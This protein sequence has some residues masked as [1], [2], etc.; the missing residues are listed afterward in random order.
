MGPVPG[1]RKGRD[2]V[3][4]LD[5]LTT[6]GQAAPRAGETHSAEASSITRERKFVSIL[7]AD[8]RESTSLVERMDPEDAD[9]ALSPVIDLM[10]K[11]AERFGGTLSRVQGDGIVA[12]FGAPRAME[13]HAIAA[14]HA[15]LDIQE[16]I[17][18]NR[19]RDIAVRIGIHSAEVLVEYSTDQR[20]PHCEA[21]GPAMHLAARIE[22]AAGPGEICI[23]SDSF[24][25]SRGY[26]ETTGPI[27]ITPKGFTDPVEVYKVQRRNLVRSR[28]HARIEQ[29]LSSF[30]SRAGEVARIDQAIRAAAAGAG[31]AVV[32]EGPAGIGK[33]RL[34][35]EA[36]NRSADLDP[37]LLTVAGAP[38]AANISYLPIT[39]ALRE[40]MRVPE[41]DDPTLQAERLDAWLAQFGDDIKAHRPAFMDLL[42]IPVDHDDAWKG[43]VPAERKAALHAAMVNAIR[44]LATD[45]T[46]LAVLEDIHWFDA[47]T[48]SVA[49]VLAQQI[50]D[51]PIVLLISQRP[52]A[53]LTL[54]AVE[55]EGRLDTIDLDA[56]AEEEA[57][58]LATEIVGPAPENRTLAQL[59]AAKSVG[60]PLYIE[61]FIHHLI[62]TRALVPTQEG[63]GLARP[64]EDLSVPTNVQDVIAARIDAQGNRAKTILQSAAAFG[65][66]IPAELLPEVTGLGEI[67][68]ATA[69]A[70]LVQAK[71][72]VET[73]LLPTPRYGFTHA[74]VQ[75]VCYASV[76]RRA[77]PS[78]H[79]N[80]VRAIERRFMTRIE[81][82]AESLSRHAGIGELWQEV[83]RYARIAGRRALERSA[84]SDAISF[85]TDALNGLARLDQS[86]ENRRTR[87]DTYLDLRAP[88]GAAARIDEMTEG[89]HQ[90]EALSREIGDDHRLAAVK[91]SQA[92]ANNYLGRLDEAKA[93]GWQGLE[94]A[95][96][97]DEHTHLVGGIYHLAQ[98]H[99]WSG[100]FAS[101]VD[102]LEPWCEDFSTGLMRVQRMGTA[103]TVSVLWQGLT[104]AAKAYLGEFAEA[105]RY[106]DKALW[107]AEEIQRPYDL[108][109]AKWYMGFALLHSGRQVDRAIGLLEEARALC[110]ATGI[111]L[112]KPVVATS[113]GY[114]KLVANQPEAAVQI[115]QSAAEGARGTGLRYGVVW[116]HCN[117]GAAL[118]ATGD[119][120]GAR[121]TLDTA[122]ADAEAHGF[123]AVEVTA[124]RYLAE[125]SLEAGDGDSAARERLSRALATAEE[126]AL[127]PE[128]AHILKALS[129]ANARRGDRAAADNHAAAAQAIYRRL[130]MDRWLEPIA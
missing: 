23:T 58:A 66:V 100:D 8:I 129:L 69:L 96:Q 67:E 87:I 51:R 95:K 130:Q 11:S 79:R 76:P 121:E 115:L 31:R 9:E 103:G 39:R 101:V 57:I 4:L 46:V 92:F 25:L 54:D 16:E 82:Y 29:G 7:F 63:Y 98:S 42:G 62:A 72:L 19:E 41:Y 97:L 116:A 83:S 20:Y 14:C 120:A 21:M 117:L 106:I 53:Y 112:L 33:S 65:D 28:W 38:D 55:Q 18:R 15:A 71:L 47:E 94:L 32:V 50:A 44:A 43:L 40:W 114:G 123:R 90:A 93:A 102:L 30:I 108:I 91:V 52:G 48:L 56:L 1:E 125:N 126:L 10:T 118:T 45:T 6:R 36:C 61:E 5:F 110:E 86:A 70:E 35:H 85:L 119:Y 74:L 84:Y 111:S 75:E 113:L 2:R 24:A 68:V 12:L 99:Q 73:R 59:I 17:A 128:R 122:L 22:A 77:R 89:L 26:I 3:R 104:G 107:I 80:I 78:L 37:F 34:L 109:M 13:D 49:E 64:I 127:E 60:N 81:D 105:V 27:S 124:R 88:L